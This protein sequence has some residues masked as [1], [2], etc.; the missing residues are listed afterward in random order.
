MNVEV[1][2]LCEAA[3]DSQGKL[4]L[5]GAFDSIWA[6]AMPAVHAAC[7]VAIRMRFAQTESGEHRVAIH[8]IDEDGQMAFQPVDGK[9]Q[10]NVRPE[11]GSAVANIVLN[12]HGLRFEHY[13]EYSV[14]LMVDG[15]EAATLPLFVRQ[16]PAA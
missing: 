15:E 8:I 7:A 13:G 12:I 6:R 10:V 4:N 14:N 5:L 16:A 3:N 2:A 11:D 9:I 1:M